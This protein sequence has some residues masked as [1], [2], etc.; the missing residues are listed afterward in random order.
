M[1]FN[2]SGFANFV[3]ITTHC[4]L[5]RHALAAKTLSA[6]LKEIL[7]TPINVISFIRSRFLNHH[8][9]KKLFQDV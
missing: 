6:T 2:T 8:I 1:P 4:F 7:S 3:K 5:Q 9:F